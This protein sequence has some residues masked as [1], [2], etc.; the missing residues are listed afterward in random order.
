[1]ILEWPDGSP[2][3]PICRSQI[4]NSEKD[5]LATR[6]VD[7][8]CSFRVAL[9]ESK[10]RYAARKFFSFAAAARKYI[11]LTRCDRLVRRDVAVVMNGLTQSLELERKR[12]P[13]EILYEADRL[14]S[15]FFAGYDP[16]FEG[17]EPPVL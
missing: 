10:R 11:E 2:V 15:L 4:D 14:E 17:D 8:W 6:V 16:H 9:T 12:V 7:L 1:V 13:G 3:Q 5:R